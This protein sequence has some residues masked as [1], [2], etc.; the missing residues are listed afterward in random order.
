MAQRLKTAFIP[1]YLAWSA[2]AL[3]YFY[4]Y[5]LRVSPGVMVTDLRQEFKM[6]A[7]QFSSLGALYLYAY[8]LLQIPL[9]IAIDRIGVRRTVLGSIILCI[10]GALMLG[11]AETLFMAQASRLLVGAGSASA[12]MAALKIAADWL[13]PG[14]RG[15][16]MGATLT[17]GT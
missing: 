9:G 2:A 15:F 16:L 8:S 10:V 5:I 3:F 14:Q 12:F 7:E 6:T 11:R 4:Q 13:S 1:L 17:L